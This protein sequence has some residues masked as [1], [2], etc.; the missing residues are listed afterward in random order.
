MWTLGL[1]EDDD[2]LL[3][4]VEWH[5]QSQHLVRS[6]DGDDDD[7]DSIIDSNLKKKKKANPKIFSQGRYRNYRLSSID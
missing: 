2:W 7:E 6:L 3:L 4:L 5:T 1:V